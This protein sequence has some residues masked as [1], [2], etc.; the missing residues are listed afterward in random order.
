MKVREIRQ[1]AKGF[2]FCVN[3][4]VFLLHL[5]AFSFFPFFSNDDDDNDVVDDG[6]DG[7]D[8]GDGDDDDDIDKACVHLQ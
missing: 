5:F 8:D 6:D 2:L 1:I 7:D 4:K 3:Y